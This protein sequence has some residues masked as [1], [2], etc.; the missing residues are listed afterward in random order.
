MRRR[1]Q[2][3]SQT[4][5]FL[6]CAINVDREHGKDLVED[7]VEDLK[8]RH[9]FLLRTACVFALQETDVWKV[10]EMKVPG[11]VCYWWVAG[12]TAI[13]TSQSVRFVAHVNTT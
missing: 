7:L 12:K 5:P 3:T 4:G 10:G 6:F 1:P 13:S 9:P 11:H 2:A 8:H